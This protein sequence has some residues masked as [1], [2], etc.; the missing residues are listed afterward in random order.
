MMAAEILAAMIM[1]DVDLEGIVP[2]DRIRIPRFI[3][4]G[5]R[6]RCDVTVDPSDS[7]T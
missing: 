5:R 6:M 1:R 7:I 2:L 4:G 3:C